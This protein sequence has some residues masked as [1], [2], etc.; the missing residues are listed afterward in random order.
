MAFFGGNLGCPYGADQKIVEKCEFFMLFMGF[1]FIITYRFILS[2][3]L[4]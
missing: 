4:I 2:Q 1:V 3:I